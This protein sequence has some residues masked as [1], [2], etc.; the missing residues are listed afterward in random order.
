MFDKLNS[1]NQ[2]I[3]DVLARL[4]NHSRSETNHRQH[5]RSLYSSPPFSTTSL[6]PPPVHSPFAHHGL[7]Q[8]PTNPRPANTTTSQPTHVSPT[9]LPVVHQ[10]GTLSSP[11]PQLPSIGS[12]YL[13][14]GPNRQ[15]DFRCVQLPRHGWTML[16]DP[17]STCNYPK[18]STN[19][20]HVYSPDVSC[21]RQRISTADQP[22]DDRRSSTRISELTKLVRLSLSR[23]LHGNVS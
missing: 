19:S 1:Y 17:Q 10:R 2:S 3:Q 15:T 13:P 14:E 16:A 7:L 23:L 20:A 9:T 21:Q 6:G 11:T 5:R 8:L 18:H 12:T 22:K 4:N